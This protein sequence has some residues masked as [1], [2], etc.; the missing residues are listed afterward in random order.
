MNSNNGLFGGTLL[1]TSGVD[2]VK[3]AVSYY[4][5]YSK[6]AW[7]G[8]LPELGITTHELLTQVNNII[9][10]E[11]AES[12][13]NTTATML[14]AVLNGTE[15]D[16]AAVE[17]LQEMAN[18]LDYISQY[19][20]NE[21]LLS[22]IMTDFSQLG[23]N[24]PAADLA[25][26]LRSMADG[27]ISADVKAKFTETGTEVG[28]DAAAGV[29]AGVSGYDYTNDAA[30]SADNMEES[31]RNAYESHSPS[32]RM[33]P[34]GND[35]A[36]GVGTGVQGYDPASDAE[37]LAA[38]MIAAMTLSMA[39]STYKNI[40]LNAMLGLRDGILAGTAAVVS[41]MRTAARDAVNAAKGELKIQSP[42]KVFRDEVGVMT[43]RGLGQGILDETKSQAK[44]I[45]N[46]AR[47]LTGEASN[48]A[49]TATSSS[50][51]YNANSNVNL[52]GN[53]FYVH[54][55]Q[56]AY[57]LAVEIASITKRQQR[58]MGLR[59]A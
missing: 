51:T 8:L 10:P 16:P 40:G 5:Q 2:A 33:Q 14:G 7:H 32:A 38:K 11:M 6:E 43:M 58:G 34:I 55:E 25:E 4:Q 1:A 56:D 22:G 44:I 20:Q 24:M 12:L 35:V 47:Y 41:A 17:Y 23:V 52:S 18:L 59:M 13:A 29:G 3:Q 48:G 28:E 36:A 15:L 31:L 37:A 42:S 27:T 21:D 19:G 50:K 9:T 39:A 46:A 45:R 57:A 49:V 54:D 53:N 30:T 26:Y